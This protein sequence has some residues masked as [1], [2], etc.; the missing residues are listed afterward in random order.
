LIIELNDHI[1]TA[2][3]GSLVDHKQWVVMC[4][5]THVGYLQKT[6]NAWLQCI[7]F[8]DEA[9]KQELSEAVA[10]AAQQKLGGVVLPVDPDTLP[11]EGEDDT[12]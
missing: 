11:D 12:E 4:D 3:D 5:G 2:P 6:E 8:M 1:G 9:T 7:V 10:E